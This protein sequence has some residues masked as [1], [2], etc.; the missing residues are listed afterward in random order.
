M[1]RLLIVML[2]AF[3]AQT[4]EYLPIGLL[5]QIHGSLNVSE[6]AVGALVTG[7][8]WIA[9]A[10]AIPLTLA[11]NRLEKRGLFLGLLGII[12]LANVS[13]ALSSTYVALALARTL[14]ALTH[15]V[16]WSILASFATRVAPGRPQ[17]VSLA[18]AFGGISLA[19]VLGVPSAN[20]I[21]QWLEWRAAFMVY[22]AIGFA[23]IGAGIRWLPAIHALA[24]D[25][26][27]RGVHGK[28]RL[29]FPAIVTGLIITAHFC[30]YTYV[31]PLL[32]RVA[33]T[34]LPS[35]PLHLLAFGAAGAAGTVF[36]GWAGRWPVWLTL[37]SGLGIVGSQAMIELG[38]AA[39]VFGWFEVVLWGMAISSLI[40]GLQGWVLKLAPERPDEASAFYVAAFNFGIGSGA[41]VGGGTLKVA[42]DRAVLWT[43]VVLGAIA[44]TALALSMVPGRNKPKLA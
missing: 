42:G 41:L 4:S 34:P 19:N 16:F 25:T 29:Y 35:I 10:S 8:A 33:K 24:T 13:A 40:I 43:G 2:A 44:C 17:S 3:V 26:A 7:Y 23:I 37:V 30:C 15:G 28:R 32:E 6:S 20:A 12:S 1:G 36:S 11:T 14:I 22:A 9:A 18:W 21:G 5:P 39:A 31:V 27:G 38:G